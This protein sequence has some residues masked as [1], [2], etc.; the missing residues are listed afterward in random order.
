MVLSDH[1]FDLTAQ[2][3]YRLHWSAESASERVKECAGVN[4][5]VGVGE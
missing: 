1:G 5:G 2:P 4:V 3:N